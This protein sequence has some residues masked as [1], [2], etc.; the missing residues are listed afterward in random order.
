MLQDANFNGGLGLD[1]KSKIT[2][3]R[4]GIKSDTGLETAISNSQS[5]TRLNTFESLILFFT[6]EV[7]HN[8]LRRKQLKSA[9]DQKVAA[10]QRGDPKKPKPRNN[11]NNCNNNA[12]VLSDTV[13]GQKVKG[14]WYSPDEFNKMTTKQCHVVIKLK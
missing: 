6:A 11:P 3:F 14:R 4:N 12:T 7:Q 5:N 8:S 9:I 1:Y 2:Y 10:N 13:N